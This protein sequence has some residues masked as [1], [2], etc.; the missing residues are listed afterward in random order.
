M[1]AKPFT[2][3]APRP[4]Y[5]YQARRDHITGSGAVSL[6]VDPL[7]G[8]V[9]NARMIESTGSSILDYSAISAFQRWRFKNGT[10]SP[11]KVPFTFT[12]SGAQF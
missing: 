12:M 7:T 3:S 2:V 8:S 6:E 1:N 11:V 10:P 4:E 9:I 5:P